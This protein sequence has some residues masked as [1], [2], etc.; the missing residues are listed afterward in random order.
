MTG[1]T[2]IRTHL[3][4][5]AL[6]VLADASGRR[7]RIACHGAALLSLETPRAGAPF[8]V[9]WG[10]RSAAEIVARAG[11]HFAV[12]APFGGRIA[13]ARY[14]FDGH[15]YDLD[16]GNTGAARGVRHGFV[17]DADFAVANLAATA[18]TARVTLTTGAIR[19]RT[20]FP[21]A[22]DLAVTF[23]L[24]AAG[25]TLEARMRNV[26]EHA[27]PCFFGWH[28]YL[29]AGNGRV[30]DW[31]LQIPARTTLRAGADLIALAGRAAYAPLDA[32][33]TLDFRQPSRIRARV[34]DNGFTD[35]A[36]NADGR[37]RTRLIDPADGF[38]VTVW[39]ER[40]VMHAFT[41]DTLARGAR[42]AIALEPMECMADAFNRAECENAI[43]LDAGAERAY[44]CGVELPLA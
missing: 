44:R 42:T 29:R 10:Y 2:A 30:D 28:A 13:D 26:G 6:V 27:A 24:D 21:F 37:A 12:L 9:A 8:D 14:T 1:F 39:Q 18:N 22:I 36:T 41:G 31:D 15:A 23:T 5:Q 16:P 32:A 7:A 19:P 40:G 34:L 43:R 35:L 38:T 33:P 25:L 4:E 11:S 3:H 20:G 17:R